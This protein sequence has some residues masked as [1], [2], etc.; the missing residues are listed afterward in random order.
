MSDVVV[1]LD[2]VRHA[3][4]VLS[5]S[6]NAQ[7]LCRR[8]AHAEFMDGFCQGVAAY[9][10]DQR[11]HLIEV[12]TY[13]RVHSFE[14]LEI[15]A[16]DDSILARAIRSRK[17]VIEQDEVSTLFALPI[18]LAG[19]TTGAFLFTLAKDVTNP[20]FS[21]ETTSMLSSL[22]GLFMDSK[23]LTLKPVSSSSAPSVE[24]EVLPVQELTTR[25]VQILHFMA[26]GLTNAEIAKL[27]LLSESTVRQE[28]IRIFRILKCHT[29]SEAI[30]KARASG[31]IESVKRV[32][33]SP[34]PRIDE[35]NESV[36]LARRPGGHF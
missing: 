4:S 5:Q 30:V 17:I 26:D 21:K 16:W 7:D 13:G 34:P 12:A 8:I 10:L 11:S 15:S 33:E 14:A 24:D 31:I 20:I 19:M 36:P 2:A 1:A 28:T 32:S 3:I 29:R 18:E 23:G 27:V 25:Q 22:G 9:L 6:S 35:I